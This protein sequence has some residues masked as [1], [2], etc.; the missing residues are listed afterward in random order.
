MNIGIIGAGGWGTALAT[1]LAANNHTITL[2]THEKSVSD[3]INLNRTNHTFLPGVTLPD[4]ITATHNPQQLENNADIFLIT[5]PTQYIRSV[6]THYGFRCQDRIVV[7]GAKGIEN[8]TL[9][10]VSQIMHDVCNI[11][12]ENFVVLTGPS[13]AEEVGKAIPT[14]VVAASVSNSASTLVQQCFSTPWFRV[15][16]SDDIIGCELGGA[17]KNVIAIAAGI[18]DG[19]NM[20]DNTKAALITRGLAEMMRIG[21]SYGADKMTFSGLSGLGDLFVTCNSRHSRN[22]Y[23]GEQIGKG[24]QLQDIL[25]E[26][27]MVAEGVSTTKSVHQLLQHRDIEMPI[28]EQMYSILFD[29]KSPSQAIN[30]LMIRQTRPEHW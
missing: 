11:Q 24:R 3:D 20:G 8:G 18:I 12:P 15:Y 30:E 17:L 27:K 6:M 26:M 21:A 9:M 22:R 19:L 7:S 1:V 4:N 5:V 14:T 25:A 29:N 28:A 13:H 23:V 10:R 16:S 2:W